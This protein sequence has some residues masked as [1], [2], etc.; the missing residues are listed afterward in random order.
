MTA[1]RFVCRRSNNPFVKLFPGITA[2]ELSQDIRYTAGQRP[3]INQWKSVFEIARRF[4][5]RAIGSSSLSFV[6]F[7]REPVKAFVH[8]FPRNRRGISLRSQH[9]PDPNHAPENHAGI[10]DPGLEFDLEGRVCPI[11]MGCSHAGYLEHRI[12]NEFLP[13]VLWNPSLFN[14]SLHFEICFLTF[15][16]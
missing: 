2:I 4:Q 16:D 3:W 15:H 12:G 7:L 11:Q 14:F 5:E 1:A 6:R 8:P 13:R 9:P 10:P